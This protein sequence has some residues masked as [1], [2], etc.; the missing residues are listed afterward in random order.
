MIKHGLLE[1]KGNSYILRLS[2]GKQGVVIIDNVKIEFLCNIVTIPVLPSVAEFSW[3]RAAVKSLAEDPFFKF[4]FTSLL[5]TAGFFITRLAGME[6][7]EQTAVDLEKVSQR[8]TRLVMRT[9][10]EPVVESDNGT[11]ALP[12]EENTQQEE[13][14][15]KPS[16]ENRERSSERSG[17]GRTKPITAQG[18]LGLI[19]G[20]GES[21]RGGS[22]VDALMDKGLV[23]ELAEVAGETN[24]KL[25]RPDGDPN[26]KSDGLQE[27]LD[28]TASGGIDD[29]LTD[30]DDGVPTVDMKKE[31]QVTI[32]RTGSITASEEAAGQRDEQSLRS[33]VQNQMPRLEYIYK[34]HL[35]RNVNLEGKVNVDI[36]I[37]AS[38]R[39]TKVDVL[40]D[41]VGNREF[42]NELL[43]T[44][45]RW[46]FPPIDRGSVVVNYPFVFTRPN[47]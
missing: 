11:A 39:V 25:G 16:N 33:V 47:S 21:E 36:H 46:R 23:Q 7:P 30:L 43:T 8:F 6:I 18:L 3:F 28:A 13:T 45:R 2:T 32:E 20:S 10:A 1:R 27:L 5:I 42:T 40:E 15:E 14:R 44:I 4:V 12:T 38:G 17:E 19:S 9:Q 29:L 34:K 35:K 37:S 22:I 26:A 31:S 24:L 41:T